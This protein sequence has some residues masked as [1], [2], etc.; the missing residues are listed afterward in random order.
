MYNNFNIKDFIAIL[1]CKQKFK[2]FSIK[3]ILKNLS[4]FS[5]SFI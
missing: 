1:I 5:L 3:T 4:I 2:K